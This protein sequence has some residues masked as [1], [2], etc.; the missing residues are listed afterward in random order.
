MKAVYI[1]GTYFIWWVGGEV[2]NGWYSALD[3]IHG[4]TSYHI[5][6]FIF[7][8]SGEYIPDTMYVFVQRQRLFLV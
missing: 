4:N 2:K 6:L 3:R 7:F 1:S 8:I 5:S